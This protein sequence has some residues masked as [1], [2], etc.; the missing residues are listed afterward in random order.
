VDDVGE[1]KGKQ[2]AVG[3]AERVAVNGDFRDVSSVYTEYIR[4]MAVMNDRKAYNF[5]SSASQ[6]FSSVDIP[7]KLFSTPI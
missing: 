5:T 6:L 3:V 2:R 4:R 1:V 7:L